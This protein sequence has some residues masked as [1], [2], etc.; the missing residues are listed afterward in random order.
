MLRRLQVRELQLQLLIE[1]GLLRDPTVQIV[2]AI[3]RTDQ[4]GLE[5]GQSEQGD[6]Q[7]H[8][9]DRAD[10]CRTDPFALGLD[11]AKG[12]PFGFGGAATFAARGPDSG[13][14]SSCRDQLLDRSQPR[15]LGARVRLD[16]GRPTVCAR[17]V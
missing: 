3:L 11:N 15:A 17:L 7:E 10:T 4:H 14:A 5:R 9:G 1:L 8:A 2:Q 6:E 16:L 12:R 13:E